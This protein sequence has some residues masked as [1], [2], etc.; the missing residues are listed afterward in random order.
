MKTIELLND[1]WEFTWSA[2]VGKDRRIYGEHV[3]DG[4]NDWYPASVPGNVQW[5]LEKLGFGEDIFFSDNADHYR[6]CEEVDF[7]YRRLLG[8]M[9]LPHGARA[10]LHFEG[11]DCLATIWID[12]RRVGQHSNMFVPYWID[13]TEYICED[14][15][16]ELLIRFAS[17]FQEVEVSH[18]DPCDHPPM[19]RIRT[20][21]A[22]ISYG[23]DIGPRIV[24]VGIWRPVRLEIINRGRILYAGARTVELSEDDK[25]AKLELVATID[26][27]SKP[28][29]IMIAGRFG[30]VEINESVNVIGGENDVVIPF[31]I[32]EP[33]LWWPNGMG[34][35][36]RYDFELKIFE[37]K[38]HDKCQAEKALD[39]YSGKFGIC[40]VDIL[41]EPREDGGLGF[42]LKVNNKDYFI[43]GMNWTP[44]DSLFG[45]ITDD[46]LR[47][48]VKLSADA[49][50]NMLRVWGG[51]V[52][53]P[54]SFLEACDEM[55]I[56]IW[57]DF[58]MACTRYPQD[59]EFANMMI[60]EVE[61]VVRAYRGHVCIGLWAGDNEIDAICGPEAG[62]LLTRRVIP[63]VLKRLDPHRPYIPSSPFS[64]PGEDPM[65]KRFGDIHLWNHVVKHDDKF[66]T[67]VPVNVVSEIGRISL[68]S[69][70][71]VDSFI[72]KDKQWPVTNWL[73]RYHSSDTNRWGIYR[74]INHVLECVK[75]CGY[76]EPKSLEE[77]IDVTQKIQADAYKFWIEYY[78]NHP[79]CW[80]LLLWNLCDCWPQVSDAVISFDLEK[81]QAYNII[82][83]AYGKL[84]R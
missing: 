25:S 75:A 8:P 52:Y 7:W 80:G 57:Q 70:K 83:A 41:E 77:L 29:E 76:P 24:T 31:E 69:K 74:N 54:E 60:Y 67:D 4:A 43:K 71:T 27:H 21:K 73:W 22:Q 20:R 39:G 66:Y 15:P 53:E 5:D 9:K 45:R 10:I 34:K 37:I 62:V 14:R 84:K 49:S 68:P 50:I 72:P 46:K 12:G 65:D 38:A 56:L 35:A 36:Y 33:E 48:L 1:G 59:S 13:V 82:K 32:N 11:L 81:K 23:W 28:T 30:D 78:G 42:R 19:Q 44:C 55:G 16:V 63:S 61:K 26:W 2:Y 6:W 64:K 3:W 51:G 79:Q 40:K 47:E 18:R 58:M 17:T